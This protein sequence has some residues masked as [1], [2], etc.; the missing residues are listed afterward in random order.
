MLSQVMNDVQQ[1]LQIVEQGSTAAEPR[2][3]QFV[4]DS[5][6]LSMLALS[7]RLGVPRSTMKRQIA[8]MSTEDL[9]QWSQE[10]DPDGFAWQR[11]GDGGEF[12]PVLSG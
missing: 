6:S 4:M 11:C 12:R 2:V 5:F 7:E 10:R 1:R 9:A 3:I 8:D